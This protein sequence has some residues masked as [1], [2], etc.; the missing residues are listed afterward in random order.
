MSWTIKLPECPALE[1][2][3]MQYYEEVADSRRKTQTD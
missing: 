2:E 3:V 1:D